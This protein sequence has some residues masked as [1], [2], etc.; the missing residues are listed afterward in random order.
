M[1]EVELYEQLRTVEIIWLDARFSCS[2]WMDIE[3]AKKITLA[4]TQTRGTILCE[5]EGSITLYMNINKSDNDVAHCV[6]IPKGCIKS[7][8]DI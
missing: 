2:T 4:E 1:A 5:D 7:I 3:E 6:T 8:K